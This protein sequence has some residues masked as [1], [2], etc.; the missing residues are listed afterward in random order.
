ML[1]GFAAVAILLGRQRWLQSLPQNDVS[2]DPVV[3]TL[4][5]WDAQLNPGRISTAGVAAFTASF[6]L[7]AALMVLAG[8]ADVGA[9]NNLEL[10]FSLSYFLTAGWLAI[11]WIVW[12][13]GNKRFE[14]RRQHQEAKNSPRTISFLNRRSQGLA[15]AVGPVYMAT[16][17][18]HTTVLGPQAAAQAQIVRLAQS[19]RGGSPGSGVSR[20]LKSRSW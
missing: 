20:N 4:N 15:S 7:T 8:S 16:T 1:S 13:P 2:S 14:V 9:R 6:C 19:S 10:G 18:F 11:I 3:S 5:K 12:Q 17:R